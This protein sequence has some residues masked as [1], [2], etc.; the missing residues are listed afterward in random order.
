MVRRNNRNQNN[1]NPEAPGFN[2][3]VNIQTFD[4]DPNFLDFFFSKLRDVAT[5]NDYNDAETLCLLKS[6]LSG[7]T[8]KFF[9]ESPDLRNVQNWNDV[10]TTFDFVL[11]Q[12]N[13]TVPLDEFKNICLLP[14]E[15]VKSLARRIN[16]LASK[17]YLNL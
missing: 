4:G 9:L 11:A 8:L 16:T 1:L 15:S 5:F 17:M 3:N 12:N 10:K 7:N 14:E 2:F 6:K 13:C